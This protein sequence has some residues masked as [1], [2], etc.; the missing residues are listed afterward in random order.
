MTLIAHIKGNV[1]S[2]VIVKYVV[3][4]SNLLKAFAEISSKAQSHNAQ[5]FENN[6]DLYTGNHICN[7]L[8]LKLIVVLLEHL[9]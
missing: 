6:Y 7:F 9:K 8:R 1:Q 5:Y 2:V 3:F 4:T